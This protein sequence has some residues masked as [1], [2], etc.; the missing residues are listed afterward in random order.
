MS[1]QLIN[2]NALSQS[3]LTLTPFKFSVIKKFI[4][5]KKMKFLVSNLPSSG[6]Y[7]S[8]REHGSDKHYNVLNKILV[9]LQHGRCQ[10]DSLPSCWTNLIS[11]LQHEDYR[12]SLSH[13]LQIDLS[14]TYQEITLKC[15]SNKNFLSPHTDKDLVVATHLI[16]LNLD[17][18]AA[19]GGELMLMNDPQTCFKR[20]I[21]RW[22]QSF[23]FVRS[24]QSW[25]AVAPVLNDDVTRMV[26]QVA[27]WRTNQRQVLPGRIETDERLVT[28]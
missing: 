6:Y 21:P 17:W 23:A 16:F 3:H 20:H 25:H 8:I 27:F 19:W 2:I 26:L 11:E 15:Y 13:L 5:Q 7:R 18:Q 24:D 12:R 1:N 10:D 28:V 22:D 9:D 4:D 14:Q